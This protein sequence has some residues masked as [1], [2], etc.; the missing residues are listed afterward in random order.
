M[1]QD[2]IRQAASNFID[3]LHKLEQGR[4]GAIDD[5]AALF[6]EDA[7]LSNPLIEHDGSRRAGRDD[8]AHFWQECRASFKDIY[9]EFTDMTVGPHSV[10]L[11][12]ESRGSDS[13]GQPLQYKGVSQLVLN[14]DG[15]IR[16]FNGY[17]DSAALR[18]KQ[19]Q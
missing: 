13:A 6:A 11:F 2:Q 3:H 15:R 4:P 7:E 1:E 5:M 9:S 12:W 8:I 17:F 18:Q 16:V 19:H 14:D 10:G